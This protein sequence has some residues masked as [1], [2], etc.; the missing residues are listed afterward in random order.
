M[1]RKKK[2]KKIKITKSKKIEKKTTF[3]PKSASNLLILIE[4]SEFRIMNVVS[5]D[6]PSVSDWENIKFVKKAISI[7]FF[8]P[9][10]LTIK[11]WEKSRSALLVP[12]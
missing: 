2:K 1:V 3:V 5:P 11:F 9:N 7:Y 4:S 8:I 6:P 12:K 10:Y